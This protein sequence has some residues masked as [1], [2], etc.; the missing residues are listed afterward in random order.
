[1]VEPPDV[2]DFGDEADRRDE[3]NAALRLQRVDDRRPAPRGRELA[4][5]VGEPLD[6]AFRF[7]D[8][9]AVYPGARCVAARGE[10]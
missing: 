3:R 9:I 7:S 2:A 8:R 4:K 6:A 10:N 1:M 5:L